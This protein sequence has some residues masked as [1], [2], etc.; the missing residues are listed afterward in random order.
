[1]IVLHVW[2]IYQFFFAEKLLTICLISIHC[3]GDIR[4][5]QSKFIDLPY[6]THGKLDRHKTRPCHI[7]VT[8]YG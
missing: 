8:S 1:M 5:N 2:V 4:R 7:F 6:I 3:N